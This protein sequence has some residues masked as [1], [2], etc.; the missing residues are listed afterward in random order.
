MKDEKSPGGYSQSVKAACFS[1]PF[2]D[3]AGGLDAGTRTKA[4]AR[5]QPK[6]FYSFYGIEFRIFHH[7]RGHGPRLPAADETKM[8]T[9]WCRY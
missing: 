6:R 8:F 1:C 3:P 2:R 7:P 5:Q 9:K 4:A